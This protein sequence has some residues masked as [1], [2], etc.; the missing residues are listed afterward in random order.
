MSLSL[1][2]LGG[3]LAI[4]GAKAFRNYRKKRTI[5]VVQSG[6]PEEP[7]RSREQTVDHYF[8]VSSLATGLA[9]TGG[10][11]LY[12]PL[13]LISM[14]LIVY[15]AIPLFQSA[16]E[17]L[18]TERRVRGAFINS[19]ATAGLFAARYYS[20]AALL[21]WLYYLTQRLHLNLEDTSKKLFI[22]LFGMQPRATAWLVKDG[23][24]VEVPVGDLAAG[25]IITVNA[26]EM[27]PVD[28][29]VTAGTASVNQRLVTG[30]A[31]PIEKNVGD[32]VFAATL[33]VD[34]R[35][36]IRVERTPW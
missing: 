16:F 13:T 20:T 14:P 27:I 30:H 9:I 22:N 19:A 18:F 11:L 21:P 2:L 26:G 33:P 4:A 32:R 24:E 3:G 7:G 10:I 23:V 29:Q 35:L 8:K 6:V 31:D 12:P 36:Q 25:D 15:S 28:G 1:L 34:G 5:A 17:D